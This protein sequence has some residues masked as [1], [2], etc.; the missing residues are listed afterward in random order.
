MTYNML[1]SIIQRELRV[2]GFDL[3]HPFH[4]SWYN[5]LIKSEGLVDSGALNVLPEPSAVNEGGI[6]YN[7]VLIG[8]TKTIWP[9]FLAWLSEQNQD[10]TNPLDMFAESRIRSVLDACFEIKEDGP[11]LKSFDLFWSNGKLQTV[12]RTK[13]CRCFN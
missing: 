4:T 1:R 7:A 3:C 8:N 12:Q 5:Q 6:V 11:K 2:K 13:L 9:I 10:V